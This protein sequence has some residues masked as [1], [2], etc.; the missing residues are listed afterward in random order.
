MQTAKTLVLRINISII[1][2]C[3]CY[4]NHVLYIDNLFFGAVYFPFKGLKC[5][6][7]I[8]PTQENSGDFAKPLKIDQKLANPEK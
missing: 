6:V 1:V 4:I 5:I 2:S 7:Q 8:C 3:L